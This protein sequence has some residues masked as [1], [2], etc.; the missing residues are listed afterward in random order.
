MTTE[1]LT[2]NCRL[3]E[4]W[5]L[6]LLRWSTRSSTSALRTWSFALQEN[7][8]GHKETRKLIKFVTSIK[9]VVLIT[10]EDL[11]S[12]STKSVESLL[13][14]KILLYTIT[15]FIVNALVLLLYQ[16]AI[17]YVDLKSWKKIILKSIKYWR[18]CRWPY[19]HRF[20]DLK[21][22]IE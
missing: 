22:D 17:N 19:W 8:F 3:S 15:T 21:W 7:C 11:T 20:T 2:R 18:T 1:L 13:Y 16:G 14:N 4:N 5:K 12:R 6:S 9:K 10:R